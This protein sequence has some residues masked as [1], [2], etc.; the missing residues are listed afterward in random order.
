MASYHVSH[1]RIS[2]S[3]VPVIRI[4]LTTSPVSSVETA[5]FLTIVSL[6]S[7]LSIII[8]K[9]NAQLSQSDRAAVCVIVFA[10][11][12]RLELVLFYGYYRSIFNHCDIISLKICRIRQKMQNKGY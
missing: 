8:I 10:K 5:S 6:S 2:S 7:D 4:R 3:A 11:S 9:Q 12:R 1:D